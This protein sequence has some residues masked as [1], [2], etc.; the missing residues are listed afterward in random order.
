MPKPILEVIKQPP[1]EAG[2]IALTQESKKLLTSLSEYT[3]LSCALAG[4]SG[5]LIARGII[6]KIR[7][8]KTY[9]KYQ[10]L[11]E[12]IVDQLSDLD[13]DLKI[14]AAIHGGMTDVVLGA[15][16]DPQRLTPGRS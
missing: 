1:M 6:S 5:Q 16:V 14:W 3:E 9:D 4:L 8:E 13:I 15:F 2:D 7:G 12:G 10:A 11:E